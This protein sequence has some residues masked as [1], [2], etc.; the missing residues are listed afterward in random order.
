MNYAYTL[1]EET[2]Q[3]LINLEKEKYELENSKH[4]ILKD[5]RG[6]FYKHILQSIK[7]N[8]SFLS[9]YEDHFE[10]AKFK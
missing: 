4:R 8:K 5:P 9:N 10:S 7:I 1:L 3:K 2:K 6:I